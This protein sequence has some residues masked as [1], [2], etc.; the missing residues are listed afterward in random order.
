M[1]ITYTDTTM[2]KFGEHRGTKM[3]DVP[4]EWFHEWWHQC[5]DDGTCS[6]TALLHYISRT[7]DIMK[8]VAPELEWRGV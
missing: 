6:D 5:L 1:S 4:V 7:I 8:V 3:R 2:I